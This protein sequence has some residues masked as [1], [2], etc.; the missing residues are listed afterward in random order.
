MPEGKSLQK[1]CV[2]FQLIM[3]MLDLYIGYIPLHAISN[4]WYY[5]CQMLLKELCQQFTNLPF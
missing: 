3:I 4:I 5:K 1:V 2:V